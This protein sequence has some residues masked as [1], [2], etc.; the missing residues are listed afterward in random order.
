MNIAVIGCGW[1]G[2]PLSK[3][4]LKQGHVVYGSTTTINKFDE[5]IAE[6]I[7]PFSVQFIIVSF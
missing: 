3:E 4:L 5:L 2:F 7:Q 1:L 6:S